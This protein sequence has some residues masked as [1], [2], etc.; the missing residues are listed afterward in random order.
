M[1]GTEELAAWLGCELRRVGR[2]C[3]GLGGN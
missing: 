3:R 1:W 2:I